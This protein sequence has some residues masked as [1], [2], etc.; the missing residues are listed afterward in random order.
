MKKPSKKRLSKKLNVIFS[1][2]MIVVILLLSIILYRQ[3][4]NMLTTSLGSI[5]SDIAASTSEIVDID[6]YVTYKTEEDANKTSYKDLIDKLSYI[7]EIS[8]SKYLYLMSKNDKGEFVYIADGSEEPSNLGDSEDEYDG[9]SDV[10]TGTPY[11]SNKIEIDDDYGT[12]ISSYYPLKAKDGS[13]IGFV[14]VDFDAS[15][16]YAALKKFQFTALGLA[17]SLI[18]I[19]IIISNFVSRQISKPIEN[20]AKVAEKVSKYDLTVEKISIN[21]KDEIGIL[22]NT[23]NIMI[24]SITEIIK[25]TFNFTESLFSSSNS[26]I[27]LAQNTNQSM[28]EVAKAIQE[29]ASSTGKQTEFIESATHKT[30]DLAHAINDI[31]SSITNVISH[32]DKVNELNVNGMNSIKLLL[33]KSMESSIAREDVGV[34]I[35]EV[36]KSSQE[37]GV[38]ID[39]INKIASQTQ[40]LSLNASIESARA[41]E[42][43][44]GFAVVAEEIRKLAEQSADATEN[45]R[46]L[47]EAI[48]QRS[49]KAVSSM[50]V[51]NILGLEQNEIIKDTERLFN[52]LANNIQDLSKNMDSIKVK[53]TNMNYKKD[54]IV[55]IMGDILRLA[56]E[57]STNTEE[58]TASTEEVLS[59]SNEFVNH[60]QSF[61]LISEKLQQEIQHFKIN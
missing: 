28:D 39:T 51:T 14:G 61:K 34:V 21:N 32:I 2:S 48:Q 52:L 37:I 44:K 10:Y 11:T 26:L 58:T 47:I 38:I 25:K 12:L 1:L 18:I 42:Y 19:I 60:A 5:A 33:S 57:N 15:Q 20:I 16:G 55:E 9:F 53:N 29:I 31:S 46:D 59:I 56:E 6:E 7:R 40:L 24:G 4:Y 43:G 30:D 41:G 8:G 17:V 13:V 49:Q 23:F 50:K 35:V 45:I 3:S 36:D 22:A 54:E 27:K